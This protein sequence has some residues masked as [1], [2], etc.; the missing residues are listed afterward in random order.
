MHCVCVKLSLS[1]FAEKR[2][3]KNKNYIEMRIQR[4]AAVFERD[5]IHLRVS[6]FSTTMNNNGKSTL[7]CG[8][9]QN[10][11]K[12]KSV[13]FSVLA[14]SQREVN[15]CSCTVCSITTIPIN[16][17]CLSIGS[18]L[19]FFFRPNNILSLSFYYYSNELH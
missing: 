15:V 12:M 4:I 7:N 14:S 1:H 13:F 5:V 3:K 9:Q 6:Q 17:L 8:T 11:I 16:C 19:L 2:K 10:R 18:N